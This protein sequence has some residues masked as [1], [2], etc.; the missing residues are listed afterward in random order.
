M[1]EESD[2]PPHTGGLSKCPIASLRQSS[3]IFAHRIRNETLC[4]QPQFDHAVTDI[5]SNGIVRVDI[6]SRIR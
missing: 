3:G 1:T 2:Q 4:P 6:K 5:S